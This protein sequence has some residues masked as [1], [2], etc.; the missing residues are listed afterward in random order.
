LDKDCTRIAKA[1]GFNLHASMDLNMC[2]E[3]HTHKGAGDV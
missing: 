2:A 3:R 1:I